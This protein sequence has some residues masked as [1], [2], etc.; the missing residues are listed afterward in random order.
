MR[1]MTDV[2][3]ESLSEI[4]GLLFKLAQKHMPENDYEGAIELLHIAKIM[5]GR[6]ITPAIATEREA[7]AADYSTKVVK[8]APEYRALRAKF[9]ACL[10]TI[11]DLGSREVRQSKTEFHAGV[12]EGLRRA[13]KIAIMFLDDFNENGPESM[14]ESNAAPTNAQKPGSHFVR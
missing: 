8:Q 13:A 10:S 6:G 12:N 2:A 5:Q 3:E 11:A 1:A 7:S 9:V 14:I 4:C